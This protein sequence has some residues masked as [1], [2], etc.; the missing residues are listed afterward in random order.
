MRRAFLTALALAALAIGG[1]GE[2]DDGGGG[3]E[4]GGG[5]SGLEPVSLSVGID[6]VY[7][8]M[9]LAQEEGIFEDHSLDVEVKQFA[10][11][12]EGVDAMVAGSIDVAG[13]ADS[14]ILARAGRTPLRALGLFVEDKGNYV[15]LVTSKDIDD[16]SQIKTM[17]IVPGSISEYGAFK[18]LRSEGID[19]ASVKMVDAGP[20]EMPA[21]L[22]NGDID[23]F[24]MWEP[25]PTR[26]EEMGGKVLMKSGDFDLSY[27]LVVAAQKDWLDSHQEEAK[28]LM[29]SLAEAAEKVEEDPGAAAD[30]AGTAAKL[31]PE[32]VE[33]AIADLDFAVRPFEA[34]DT[35]TWNEIA[36]FLV[37]RKLVPEKP[38][39][40]E[41]LSEGVVGGG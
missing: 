16:P 6:S 19:P 1:C 9:F 27:M 7:A 20:P 23:A 35:R 10:Q 4:G 39:V 38:P 2:D 13:S 21:L 17:G 28:A 15:K 32:Q 12:G 30:A 14:T 26:A 33:G 5:D 22:Q 11:G 18:L 29:D 36:D 24:V 8:P 34:R 37:E 40:Q 25:W 31:P 3:A 41:V